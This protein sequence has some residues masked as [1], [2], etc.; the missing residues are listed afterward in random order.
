MKKSAGLF[1]CIILFV[2]LA[3]LASAE[4]STNLQTKKKYGKNGKLETISYVNEN[5]DIIF[6]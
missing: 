4:V 1:L 3:G 6:A 2:C 5:E